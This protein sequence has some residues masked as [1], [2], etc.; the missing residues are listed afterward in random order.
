MRFLYLFR[1]PET[2]AR[3][4]VQLLNRALDHIE[5]YNRE[6][7]IERI[8][9]CPTP[10]LERFTELVSMLIIR[11]VKPAQRFFIMEDFLK[12]N[13]A[14]YDD[15]ISNIDKK[16]KKYPIEDFKFLPIQHSQQQ[17]EEL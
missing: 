6:L 15:F 7:I 14:K 13:S 11:D 1:F 4:S 16:I 9:T 2:R 5:T 8:L 10:D 17:H 3:P 12:K